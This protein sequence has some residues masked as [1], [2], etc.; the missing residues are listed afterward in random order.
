MVEIEEEVAEDQ[1]ESQE[2]PKSYDI[3]PGASDAEGELI[4]GYCGDD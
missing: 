3:P 2:E 4:S 1:I